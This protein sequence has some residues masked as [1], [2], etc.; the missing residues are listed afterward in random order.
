MQSNTNLEIK[1][2]LMI[3]IDIKI[4]KEYDNITSNRNNCI[5]NIIP[6]NNFTSNRNNCNKCIIYQMTCTSNRNNNIK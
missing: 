3:K 2:V 1:I 4:V 5:T 6:N